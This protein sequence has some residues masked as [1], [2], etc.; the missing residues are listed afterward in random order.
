MTA[1]PRVT[2]TLIFM[3]TIFNAPRDF[4]NHFVMRRFRIIPGKVV[5]EYTAG[6]YTSLEE[7]RADVPPGCYNLGRDESDD[8]ATVE[9]WV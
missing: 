9:T 1:P 7:A 8:P 2:K 5:P 6:L 4:P 3:Y